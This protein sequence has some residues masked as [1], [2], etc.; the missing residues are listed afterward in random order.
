VTATTATLASV[1]LASLGI[2]APIHYT[3]G[4]YARIETVL[5]DLDYLGIHQIRT[6]AWWHGMQGEWAYDRA[7]R[8][9]VRFDMVL[10]ATDALKP[11]LAQIAQFAAAHPGSLVAIEGPNEINNFGARYHGMTGAPAAVAFQDDLYAGVA[12]D[13]VLR[14]TIVYSYT[15]NAG[16]TSTSG[17]DFAA[18]HPYAVDG[19]PPRWFLA[20]NIATV[21]AG[22]RFVVTETGY[23]TLPADKDGIDPETQAVY[24]LD[25]LFDAAGAGAAAV[26]LYELL[27]A[28]PDPAGHDAGKH[29][30]LFDY[31]NR[32][33][34]IATA[35]HNLA[36]ILAPA[37]GAFA[38]GSLDFAEAG[39]VPPAA[40]MLLQKA[41]AVFD[42]VVW[43]ETALW[44]RQTH[45]AIAPVVRTRTIRFGT[46]QGRVAVYDPLR[47]TAPVAVYHAV[48]AV[49]LALG[50]HP[51]VVE[52]AARANGLGE[53]Q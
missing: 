28:Y 31:D 23:P 37:S 16:A 39:A 22:E 47:G 13:P 26:F 11:A 35:L 25:M 40:T 41:P 48:S 6:G 9:G 15:M 3:D 21:P 44:N 50:S 19:R 10:G 30:G 5:A 53:G 8:R 36:Q 20:N 17:Y 33:K 24:N 32:P 51:L 46:Q 49:T 1:F 43:D 12:A 27:D 29:F 4:H 14:G 7:A 38:P 34:P 42:L 52:V 45:R 2:G 18:I